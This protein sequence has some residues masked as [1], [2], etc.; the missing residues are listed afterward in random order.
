MKYPLRPAGRLTCAAAA[1]V[2]AAPAAAQVTATPTVFDAAISV[3][4]AETLTDAQLVL[5][6]SSFDGEPNFDV[7]FEALGD[8]EGPATFTA[9]GELDALFYDRS[10]GDFG[11]NEKIHAGLLANSAGG[12][13]VSFGD[14]A[15][16][17][18]NERPVAERDFAG[19]LFRGVEDPAIANA[20]LVRALAERDTAYL[21]QILF[22]TFEAQA[23]FNQTNG[24][25]ILPDEFADDAVFNEDFSGQLLAFG[26]LREAGTFTAR[27]AL[28]DVVPEPATAAL[29]GFGAL[30]FACR[31]R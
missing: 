3:D 6:S 26:P 7:A 30:V 12:L 21:R 17:S 20:R 13:V 29:L 24:R 23:V 2:S 10:R 27:V 11:D 18:I 4:P 16:T 25:T 22:D 31:R 15:L 1:F 19:V 5:W 28:N 14:D 9:A 8:I